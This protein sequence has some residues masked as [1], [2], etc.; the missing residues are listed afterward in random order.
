[1][2]GL[3][4]C[5]IVGVASG[6]VVWVLFGWFC[7]VCGWYVRLLRFC[8]CCSFLFTVVVLIVLVIVVSFTEVFLG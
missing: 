2:P 3:I 5:L 6:L 1:M 7:R 8:Y 4:V